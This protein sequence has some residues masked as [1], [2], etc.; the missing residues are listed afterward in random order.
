M[1]DRPL[2]LLWIP[3]PGPYRQALERAGLDR[4]IDLAHVPP[5]ETPTP[6]LLARAQ[7]ML[8]YRSGPGA[9]SYTH[10]TLPT[11]YSV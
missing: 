8:A 6:D 5:A 3:E 10:L 1:A 2:V 4:Q 11:I 9:V 7:A